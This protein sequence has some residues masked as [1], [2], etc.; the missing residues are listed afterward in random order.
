MEASGH[1][2][3]PA[4]LSTG[5]RNPIAIEKNG[6]MDPRAGHDTVVENRKIPALSRIRP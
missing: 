1:L 6:W 3:N 5:E 4:E 2:H